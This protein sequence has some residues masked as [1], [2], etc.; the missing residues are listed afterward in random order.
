MIDTSRRVFLGGLGAGLIAAPAIVRAASLMPVRALKIVPPLY[1]VR[2]DVAGNIIMGEV[3]YRW[4]K[5]ASV[6]G[7]FGRSFSALVSVDSP[8]ER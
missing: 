7:I 6:C 2:L 1:S 4:L 3:V 5:G 8:D